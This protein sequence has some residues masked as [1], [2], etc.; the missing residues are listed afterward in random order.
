MRARASSGCSPDIEASRPARGPRSGGRMP[1]SIRSVVVFPAPFGP[2]RPTTSEGETRRLTSLTAA[3]GPNRFWSDS[4]VSSVIERACSAAS[5][6]KSRTGEPLSTRPG[7]TH[8]GTRRRMRLMLRTILSAFI[9]LLAAASA[10]FAQAPRLRRPLHRQDDAGGLLPHRRGGREI[11]RASTPVV[12]DG[13]WPGSRT[14]PARRHE[15]RPVLLRGRSTRRPTRRST[16]AA[17]RRSTASGKRPTSRSRASAARSTNR[18]ASR[19][20]STRCRSS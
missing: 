9:L 1:A 19:G 15:P 5:A 12:S 14:Q 11:V 4:A 2:S 10:A 20:R 18:C 17:S 13:P 16:R 8:R 7:S 6:G 3:T